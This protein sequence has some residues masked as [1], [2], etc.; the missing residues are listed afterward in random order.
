MDV[1]CKKCEVCGQPIGV[2]E[3]GVKQCLPVIIGTASGDSRHCWCVCD[4]C[5][6][7]FY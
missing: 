1:K 5:K 3:A 4:D 7:E 2:S 6:E